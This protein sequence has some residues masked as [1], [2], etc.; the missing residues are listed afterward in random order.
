[1]VTEETTTNL[2][3][4][5][6]ENFGKKNFSAVQKVD[7]ARGIL[8]ARGLYHAGEGKFVTIPEE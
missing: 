2:I 4:Q 1:M 8:M 7:H 5:F 3:R 6:R